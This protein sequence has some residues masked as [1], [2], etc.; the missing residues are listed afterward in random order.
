MGNIP[1]TMAVTNK[2]VSFTVHFNAMPQ[3]IPHV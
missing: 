3:A 1:E 2:I